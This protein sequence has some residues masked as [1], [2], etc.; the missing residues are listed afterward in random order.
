MHGVGAVLDLLPL[1]GVLAAPAV[2]L[3]RDETGRECVQQHAA[4]G[5]FTGEIDDQVVLGGFERG[6]NAE[7]VVRACLVDAAEGE[8]TA[9]AF[10]GHGRNG[11]LDQ[12]DRGGEVDG[13]LAVEFGLGDVGQGLAVLDRGGDD[14]DVDMAEC[15]AGLGD[16]AA[17]LSRRDE[18]GLDG[19]AAAAEGGDGGAGFGGGVGEADRGVRL[20][21]G[22]DGNVGA[23]GGESEATA[24]PMLTEPPVTR[25]VRPAREKMWPIAA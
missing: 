17:G 15:G 6:I 25:A 1:R 22:L 24:R 8:N 14:Q 13:E 5:V 3:G 2:A 10:L 18:V 4:T 19:D 12:L 11:G 20:G 23:G 7:R 16:C 9:P 21:G